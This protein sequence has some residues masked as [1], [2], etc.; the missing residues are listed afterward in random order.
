MISIPQFCPYFSLKYCKGFCQLTNWSAYQHIK[1]LNTQDHLFILSLPQNLQKMTFRIECY[2][3][4]DKPTDIVSYRV[5][6]TRLI[7][8]W[9]LGPSIVLHYWQKFVNRGC[10]I[11]GIGC[12]LSFLE[13]SKLVFLQA[14][15]VIWI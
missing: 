2:R 4:T 14:N 9:K 12:M 8:E 11:A 7:K 15:Q 1:T 10:D 3:S 5:A 13:N 6:C